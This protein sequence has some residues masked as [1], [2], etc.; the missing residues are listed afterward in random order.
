[1][2]LKIAYGDLETPPKLLDVGFAPCRAERLPSTS[3]PTMSISVGGGESYPGQ[4]LS[5]PQLLY[6]AKKKLEGS[7]FA[8]RYA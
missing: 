4:I 5:I 3:P 1:M 6:A 2:R 8:G 7:T